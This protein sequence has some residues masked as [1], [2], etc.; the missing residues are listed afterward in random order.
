MGDEP[1]SRDRD[2][3]PP[4]KRSPDAP[5]RPR[6]TPATPAP[7]LIDSDEETWTNPQVRPLRERDLDRGRGTGEDADREQRR[8]DPQR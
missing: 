6:D 3:A 4:G 7:P 1:A 2:A 8:D 5:P